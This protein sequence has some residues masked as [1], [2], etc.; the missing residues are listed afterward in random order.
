VNAAAGSPGPVPLRGRLRSDEPMARHTAWGVGGPAARVYEPA[1]LDDL[2]AFLAGLPAAEPVSWVGLGSNLLVRDGGIAGTVILTAG[3]LGGIEPSGATGVRAEAGAAC[4]KVA[5]WSARRGLGGAEFLAGIPGTVGGALAMNAGAFGGETWR[6]VAAVECIDRRGTRRRRAAR[7]F[8]IGYR[9]VVRPADEWFVAA[10]LALEQGDP[11]QSLARI[12]E[13]LRRR[14][15]TQPTGARS[16]GSVFRNPP[17]DHAA[18]LIESCG[19]KGRRVG[20]AVVSEKHANFILNAGGASARDI[21]TLIDEVRGA[22]ERE[23]GVRL[24]PEVHVI[25][26]DAGES[27]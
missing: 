17:G 4:A 20:G 11:A 25:G 1:D 7:E 26:R 13:L 14:G 6:I 8:D 15:E 24:V 3:L 23:R 9:H 5:R 19:L 21:E 27:R 18:R 10:E 2:S 16:C 22:V 12:R